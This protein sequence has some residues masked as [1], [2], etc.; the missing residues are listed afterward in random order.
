MG[1]V[2][3]MEDIGT[4]FKSKGLYLS[5]VNHVL[6]I[7]LTYIHMGGAILALAFNA[8]HKLWKWQTSDGKTM[9]TF[10]SPPPAATSVA[11][12]PNDN[13]VAI[14]FDDCSIHIYNIRIDE[15]KSE[16]KGH[17]SRVTGLTFSNVLNV[18][19]SSGADV[20]WF[21][22]VSSGSVTD[23]TYSCQGEA[24]VSHLHSEVVLVLVS[25]LRSWFRMIQGFN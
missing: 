1:S 15:V 6:I 19:V 10:M 5:T 8:V 9:T 18:L 7:G 20:Q 12:H 25:T 24:G 11:F 14:G 2:G 21:S 22:P 17:Q 4:Y 16:L 13:T 23:A 3:L